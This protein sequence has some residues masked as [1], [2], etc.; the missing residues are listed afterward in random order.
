MSKKSDLA[1][2]FLRDIED[3]GETLKIDRESRAIVLRSES[4]QRRLTLWRLDLMIFQFLAAHAALAS[5]TATEVLNEV[6]SR[7]G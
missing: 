4:E 6:L 5:A 7:I 1:D 2:A 3:R